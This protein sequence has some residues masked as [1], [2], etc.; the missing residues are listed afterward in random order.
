MKNIIAFILLGMVVTG[1]AGSQGTTI[2]THGSI[3]ARQSIN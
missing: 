1:C 3:E 2:Q